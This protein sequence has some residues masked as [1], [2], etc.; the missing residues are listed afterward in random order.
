MEHITQVAIQALDEQSKIHCYSFYKV[1]SSMAIISQFKKAFSTGEDSP[2]L[3]TYHTQLIQNYLKTMEQVP[4]DACNEIILELRR[5]SS[6]P[7][8][9]GLIEELRSIFIRRLLE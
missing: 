8:D 7:T 3:D 5:V 2:E 4:E 9:I 1:L 6:E